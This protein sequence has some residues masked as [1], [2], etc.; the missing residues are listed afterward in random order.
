[1][2]Y[3]LLILSLCIW[4]IS[5][6]QTNQ[7]P[8]QIR[9]QMAKIR[10]T[11][12]WDDPV[13]AQK[14][15]DQIKVLAK[16]LMMGSNSNQQQ[17]QQRSGKNP[18]DAQKLNELNEEMIDQRMNVY[19]QVWK[20]AAGGE[21]ADILLA[22]PLRKEIVEEYQNDEKLTLNP[23]LTDDMTMLVLDMTMPGVQAVIDNMESFKSISTLIISGGETGTPVDLSYIFKKAKNYPL[24]EL[25]I[26]SF[27]NYVTT[28]PANI[29]QF[30]G[31]IILDLY[32]NNFSSLPQEMNNLTGLKV[33]YLDE[34]PLKTVFPLIT[35]FKN[36]ET[37]GLYKT[38]IPEDEVIRIGQI[39]PECKI[40]A[41]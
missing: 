36:L 13:A 8:E 29:T 2:K 23:V 40:T 20:S 28:L 24:T 3:F 7:T 38:K 15:N 27:R 17:Q 25:Y 31:L 1:M 10:Q 16:K 6:S 26:F 34:N 12:N 18:N 4:N 33:L 32:G 19:S 30:S 14:A 41:K 9:Q 39:Y 22:E 21:G 37:L 35:N 11:T 5:V